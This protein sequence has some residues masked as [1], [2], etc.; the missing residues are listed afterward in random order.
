MRF[1]CIASPGSRRGA[2]PACHRTASRWP[3][4]CASSVQIPA[5]TRH[6]CPRRTL[7]E[8]A[9][10]LGPRR[11]GA[12]QDSQMNPR[13][14]RIRG[15]GSRTMPV[16][17]D[18]TSVVAEKVHPGRWVFRPGACRSVGIGLLLHGRAPAIAYGDSEQPDAQQGHSGRLWDHYQI[19]WH[20]PIHDVV[21]AFHCP[22]HIETLSNGRAGNA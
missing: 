16:G 10:A 11:R 5:S 7:G 3:Q 12:F 2:P 6:C 9:E 21:T 22:M 14:K 17:A 13:Q 8:A 1:V 15:M 18:G 19:A 20:R 4:G